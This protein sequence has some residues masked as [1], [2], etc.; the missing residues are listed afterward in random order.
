MGEEIKIKNRRIKIKGWGKCGEVGMM[1]S[2]A[3]ERGFGSGWE[4]NR[5]GQIG[6]AI[7]TFPIL[8]FVFLIM[9]IFV[10][11][12][13]TIFQFHAPEGKEDFV[14]AG[15]EGDDFRSSGFLFKEI[16][17]DG[18]KVLVIEAILKWAEAP[19]GYPKEL[20][21]GLKSLIGPHSI[22]DGNVEENVETSNCLGVRYS[23]STQRRWSSNGATNE[24]ILR[25]NSKAYE[26]RGDV[27]YATIFPIKSPPII[28][29]PFKRSNG[30]LIYI[31][32][33]YG[34]CNEFEY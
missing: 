2:G 32:Y 29:L 25:Y 1:K 26:G 31:S 3:G 8:I 19:P 21:N 11:L 7:T 12:S 22:A 27:Q 30:E 6:Q 13:M 4:I 23:S 34:E 24:I 9:A 16:E 17:V 14:S 5:R 33:F 15:F 18:E 20:V 28:T 10:I